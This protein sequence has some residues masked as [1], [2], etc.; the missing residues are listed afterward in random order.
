MR[1]I[2]SRTA[3]S[4]AA[5]AAL[6]AAA[7][8]LLAGCGGDEPATDAPAAEE[9]IEDVL[10]D[11]AEGESPGDEPDIPF[12]EIPGDE[13]VEPAFDGLYDDEFLA[14]IDFYLERPVVLSGE[15]VDVLTDGVFAMSAAEDPGVPP[16]LVVNSE[17]MPEIAA[18]VPVR[19]AGTLEDALEVGTGEQVQDLGLDDPLFEEYAGAPLLLAETVEAVQPGG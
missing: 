14:E 18:G 11:V 7:G 9:P 12:E 5:A 16:I 1:A 10:D 2:R 17:P 8:L 15:V 4:R 19:V 3:T 6:A 13:L